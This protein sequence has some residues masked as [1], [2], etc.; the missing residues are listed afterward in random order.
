MV[1]T[2]FIDYSDTSKTMHQSWDLDFDG[3]NDCENDGTC[4]DSVDYTKAKVYPTS[5]LFLAA[6]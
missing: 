3:M 2:S 5:A 6:E 1:T 4:D